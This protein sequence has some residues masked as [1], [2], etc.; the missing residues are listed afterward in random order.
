[1]NARHNPV[2][3]AVAAAIMLAGVMLYDVM[4]AIIK[5][6]G[7]DYS[8][9]LLS[10][11]RNLFGLIP[12]LFILFWSRNWIQVGRPIVI[13]QWKFALARGSLGVFAQIS[14]YLALFHLEFATAT[15]IVFAGPLFT[16]ALSVPLLGHRVGLWR[17]LAVLIGFVGV[18][19]VMRPTGESF[20]WYTILPLCA[21]LGYASTSVTAR[22]FDKT[23]PTAI[24]NL[25][26]SVGTLIG[27]TILVIFT[28]GFVQI[29][30]LE[31]WTWIAAMG[32]AGGFAAYCWT[33]AFRLADPSSLSPFQYLGIPFSFCLGWVFF[34]ET[35]IEQLIPGAFL[36]IGGGLMI[37]WREHSFK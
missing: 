32:I 9:P 36:I 17:W 20:T 23:V 4:G 25:Y 3:F 29:G 16:T 27:T 2:S 19:L 21:A 35:P 11:Y 24:I 33:S 10:M 1:M 14:F 37:I 13:R 6:L 22:L 5:H 26:Y 28:G 34:S 15:T 31:D 18:V 12:T 7:Q 8:A 30:S